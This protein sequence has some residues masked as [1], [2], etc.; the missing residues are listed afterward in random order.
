MKND[1]E[2]FKKQEIAFNSIEKTNEI[3]F[4]L[5]DN[6]S[7]KERIVNSPSKCLFELFSLMPK[8]NLKRATDFVE[9][10]SELYTKISIPPITVEQ[11]VTYTEDVNEIANQLDH[12]AG[13]S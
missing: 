13:L 1:V 4:I 6:I 7:L 11:F 9:R 12:L 5:F 8:L 10:V 2:K 3:C